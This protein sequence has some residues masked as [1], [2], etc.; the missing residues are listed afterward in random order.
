MRE[1]VRAILIDHDGHLLTIKRIKPG[2]QP[3]WVLPGGGV[4]DTDTCLEDALARELREELGAETAIHALVHVLATT[5]DR[6][7]F[8]LARLL[9]YNLAD[10]SGPELTEPGRGQ[11]LAEHVPLTEAGIGAITLQPPQ[12]AAF[13]TRSLTAPD[14]LFTLPDLRLRNPERQP[15]PAR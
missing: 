6:Q 13:L 4:E 1:R 12:I 7:H 15:Q 9:H 8:F 11:Y 14:G 2:Q 3:Y 10:R 5:H